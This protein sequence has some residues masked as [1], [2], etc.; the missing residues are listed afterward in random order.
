MS[1]KFP[2]SPDGEALLIEA[3]SEMFESCGFSGGVL[4]G[5]TENSQLVVVSALKPE[6]G[7]TAAKLLRLAL[8]RAETLG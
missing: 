5:V 3:A 7:L 8:A 2:I 1:Q 6:D 4:L